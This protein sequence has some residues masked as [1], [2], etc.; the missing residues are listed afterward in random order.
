MS[1][2]GH[3][4]T[5]AHALAR[6]RVFRWDVESA[7]SRSAARYSCPLLI[8]KTRLPNDDTQNTTPHSDGDDGDS[9]G[10]SSSGGSASASAAAAP[11]P[12]AAEDEAKAAR[13]REKKRRQAQRRKD[14]NA[15]GED[16]AVAVGA[17]EPMAAAA[18][19]PG[20]SLPTPGAAAEDAHLAPAAAPVVAPTFGE[21]RL[22]TIVLQ[23][24]PK[25][26]EATA[27]GAAGGAAAPLPPPTPPTPPPPL[28]ALG[29]F[30]AAQDVA[31]RA[32]PGKGED[33]WLLAPH[34]VF[35]LP[36]P[37][38]RAQDDLNP[39]AATASFSAY[40]IFDGHGGKAASAFAARHLLAHVAR[41]AERCSAIDALRQQQQQQHQQQ[42]QQSSR[43]LL[44]QDAL[45][46]A[47]PWA[48]REGFASADAECR[49]RFPTSGTTA[50]LAV[51]CGFLLAVGS[52]GDS[53]AFL[54]TGKEVVQMSG[55]HRLEDSP[56]ER[57]RVLA[58][59]GECFFFLFF[60][61]WLSSFPPPPPPTPPTPLH[62]HRSKQ[63]PA[64]F[65]CGLTCQ[66][67]CQ[68]RKPP[69]GGFF[70]YLWE[71][72]FPP[73]SLAL[74]RPRRSFSS[75]LPPHPAHARSTS[76]PSLL[77]LSH[78]THTH[79]HTTDTKQPTS[80][81]RPST[82]SLQGPCA[83]GPGG[84]PC[85]ARSATPLP[86]T[87]RAPCPRC[88]SPS[89]LRRGR[90]WSSRAT[91]SGTASPPRPRGP[92]RPAAAPRAR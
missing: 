77:C 57:A 79:T 56:A 61:F 12:S 68:K 76:S 30:P 23:H 20:S 6:A 51:Q 26:A 78:K 24:D 35:G 53:H 72:P 66:K 19:T 28:P 52:V 25:P 60:F 45:A 15:N 16:A 17:A 91:A 82:A 11:G 74:P 46:A 5:S 59:G 88:A 62:P 92:R 21:R 70:S 10:G 43:L 4:P 9:D 75:F 7:V 32:V 48:L 1:G 81:P 73:P 55:N 27:E 84:S 42:Q 80:P 31:S 71:G 29:L 39:P 90:A 33:K 83:C 18:A 86:A 8:A 41:A 37:T 14:A 2:G 13:R 50:T 64:S 22:A 38:A 3:P 54:D 40:G 65:L 63:A 89:C 69:S 67:R 87:S 47:L 44:A 34:N 49:R 85:R 36:L 58:E